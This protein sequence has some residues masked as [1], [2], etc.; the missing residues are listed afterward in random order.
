M[1][2]PRPQYFSSDCPSRALFDEIAGKWSAMVLKVQNDGPQR[3]NVIRRRLEGIAQKALTQ[4]FRRLERN[5]L[6]FENG[7]ADGFNVM[8]PFPPGGFD[9]F[10]EQVVPILRNRGLFRQDYA[11][12]TLR[13][14]YSLD[15]PASVFSRSIEAI[16]RSRAVSFG[17]MLARAGLFRFR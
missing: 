16:V 8:P 3:F 1:L 13:D 14:H 17:A 15:H 4:C 9:L 5:R 12:R 7:A 10:S 6:W 2:A 11:G